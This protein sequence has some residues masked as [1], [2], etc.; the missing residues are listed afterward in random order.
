LWPFSDRHNR[1]TTR[2]WDNAQ[3]SFEYFS[4]SRFVREYFGHNNIG[5]IESMAANGQIQPGDIIYFYCHGSERRTH[6]A[7]I[8]EI[9]NFI[10]IENG[11]AVNRPKII[12]AQH[13]SSPNLDVDLTDRWF[14]N[15]DDLL[16]WTL[17][18]LAL[19]DEGSC[20]ED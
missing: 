16:G 18:F 4:N 6:A 3:L 13:S 7:I 10:V 12:Y 14:G 2:A 11:Q 15:S 17:Y 5:E 20:G 19:L 8:T 9:R 1:T